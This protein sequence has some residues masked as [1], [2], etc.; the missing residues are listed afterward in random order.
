MNKFGQCVPFRTGTLP[1]TGA[2]PWPGPG[3]FPGNC[4]FNSH[5][6]KQL[7][8]CVPLTFV[9]GPGPKPFPG[10]CGNNQHWDKQQK[11]CLP[12]FVPGPAEALP[13]ELREQQALG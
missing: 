11:Q 7:K 4:G 10:N 5:W 6:D 12:N 2:V 8:Q 3:P 13:R 1:R 9:P